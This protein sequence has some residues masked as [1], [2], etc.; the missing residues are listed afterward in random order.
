MRG[1][2]IVLDAHTLNKNIETESDRPVSIDYI[3]MKFEKAKYFSSLYLTAGYHQVKIHEE[4][5][6]YTAFLF[7][8]RAYQ[9]R[10]LPFGLNI[11]VSVFICALDQAL[12]RDLVQKLIMYVDDISLISESWEQHIDLLGQLLKCCLEQGITL[13]ISKS[14]FGRKEV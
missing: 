1:I 5:R 7:E 13:K 9:Y 8:G 3:L 11:S 10:V 12:G 2:R 6:K 4:S 14:S